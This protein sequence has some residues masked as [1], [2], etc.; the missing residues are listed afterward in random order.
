[1]I[2]SFVLELAM[3]YISAILLNMKYFVERKVMPFFL[4][5]ILKSIVVQLR[6]LGTL[7]VGIILK[8]C[9]Y[10]YCFHFIFFLFLQ[11]VKNIKAKGR[12]GAVA[13]YF[14]ISV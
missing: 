12:R 10:C 9:S 14:V 7:I 11:I 13:V 6:R 2:L 8:Y 5:A 4:C 1:M 3:R